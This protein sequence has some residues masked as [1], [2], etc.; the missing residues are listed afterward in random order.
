MI[1]GEPSEWDRLR[2]FAT[3]KG[4]RADSAGRSEHQA[5]GSRRGSI[6]ESALGDWSPGAEYSRQDNVLKRRCRG[7]CKLL[8]EVDLATAV[9]VF[10]SDESDSLAELLRVWTTAEGAEL[11]QSLP[12]QEFGQFA[13]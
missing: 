7:G 4:T 13:G 3:T 6:S 11:A 5:G 12:L 1:Q 8:E 2:G 9:S 10:G